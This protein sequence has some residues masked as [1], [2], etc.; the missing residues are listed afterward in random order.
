VAWILHWR[1]ASEVF[2]SKFDGKILCCCPLHQ[3]VLRHL[4]DDFHESQ[5][6]LSWHGHRL[7]MWI[8]VQAWD[9]HRPTFCPP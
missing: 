2:Q 7:F 8:A 4:N 1:N 3:Q 6:E 5:H 9:L